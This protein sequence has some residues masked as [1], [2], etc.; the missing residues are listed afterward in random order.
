MDGNTHYASEQ[1]YRQT[2]ISTR[3]L[4]MCG[5]EVHRFTNEEILE[6]GDHNS[7]RQPDIEGF[8]RLLQ[9]EGLEPK[10]MVFL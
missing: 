7:S 2:L 6:L 9:M 3:W 5:F 8:I 4:R 1:A 10:E